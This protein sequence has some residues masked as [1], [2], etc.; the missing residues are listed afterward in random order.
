MALAYAIDENRK[1]DIIFVKYSF[2]VSANVWIM[3]RVVN[4]RCVQFVVVLNAAMVASDGKS[5]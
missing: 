3:A 2:I 4:F 1:S 5:F